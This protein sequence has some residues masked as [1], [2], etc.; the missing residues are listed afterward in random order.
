MKRQ[1]EKIL[2]DFQPGL[3]SR[4]VTEDDK[5]ERYKVK[6]KLRR[7]RFDIRSSR[8]RKRLVQD[9]NED[10]EDRVDIRDLEFSLMHRNKK[11]SSLDDWQ[12]QLV[13]LIICSALYPQL[14]IGD[15]HNTH[16]NSNEIMFHTPGTHIN[17][18][19]WGS[20]NGNVR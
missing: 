9:E 19:N 8:K 1:F 17:D 13:K 7:E 3:A 6:E 2:N 20:I 5:E 18:I 15:E 4:I 10:E 11:V 12:I 14:A 16:R